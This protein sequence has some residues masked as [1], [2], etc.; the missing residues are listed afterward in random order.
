MVGNSVRSDILPVLAIGGA[1]VHI[2]HEHLW[3]HEHVE[4]HVDVPTLQSM[5]ELPAWLDSERAR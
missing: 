1:A 2:P 3:A 4:E 5:E